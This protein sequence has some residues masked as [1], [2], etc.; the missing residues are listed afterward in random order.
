[1]NKLWAILTVLFLC[2]ALPYNMAYA[3]RKCTSTIEYNPDGTKSIV[4]DCSSVYEKNKNPDIVRNP[5]T[6]QDWIDHLIEKSQEG[7]QSVEDRISDR[8]STLSN[9]NFSASDIQ[10]KQ[11]EAIDDLKTKEEDM[12]SRR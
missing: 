9:P 4:T 7:I 5:G 10:E 6:L 11:Q 8:S 3:T 2:F 12:Q 1:M